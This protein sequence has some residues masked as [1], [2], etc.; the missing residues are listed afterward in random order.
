MYMH[1]QVHVYTKASMLAAS[2]KVI[3]SVLIFVVFVIIN[4]L[5]SY[6]H[7]VVGAISVNV[8]HTQ[9]R[10]YYKYEHIAALV[11]SEYL[12]TTASTFWI[13]IHTHTARQVRQCVCMNVGAARAK[14]SRIYN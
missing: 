10:A 5:V 13:H 2:N 6:V 12:L 8:V 9:I 7:V 3:F 4:I 14:C 1:T 11:L